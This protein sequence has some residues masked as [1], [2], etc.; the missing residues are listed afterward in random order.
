MAFNAKANGMTAASTSPDAPAT[1][2]MGGTG[3]LG[4]H[5]VLELLERGHRVTVLA[6]DLPDEDLFPDEVELTLADLGAVS[7]DEL[8]G[9]LAGRD[10]LVFAM[11]A[12]DRVLPDAPAYDFFHRANVVATERV[13]RLAREAGLRR[14]VVCGSYFAYFERTRPQ[15]ALAEHHP[16][17]RARRDQARA[18]LEAGGTELVVT[19]LEL[20]YIFGSMPGRKPLWAPL[21]D[22]ID[23]P[24]PLFY[25]A[26]GTAMVTV[27]RVAEAI[28]GGCERD[29]PSLCLP[30]GDE[31]VPWTR[32]VE[33][34]SRI[35]GRQQRVVE[36]PAWICKLGAWLFLWFTRIKGK[37]H[38]LHPVRFID[39]QCG[40]T[41]IDED[42]LQA[43]REILGFGAGGLE[44]A[45]EETVRASRG[46]A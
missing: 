33:T 1:L 6:L 41:Y 22:Y 14:V 11:G 19:V 18:A 30:V 35:V 17:I 8:R 45:W 21:V 20:P 24:W 23:S 28:A 39:V 44:E 13:V 31:S 29:G 27:Q 12:D 15:L 32:F 16:Y 37:E 7:D 42:E 34:L 4:Y 25:T 46:G 43:A 26:G 3:F 10:N 36:V 9:L 2:V 38:G 40:E 5:A